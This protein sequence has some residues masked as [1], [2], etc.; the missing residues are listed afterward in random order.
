MA[1]YLLNADHHGNDGIAHLIESKKIVEYV[2]DSFNSYD[3]YTYELMTKVGQDDFVIVDTMSSL[4]ETT[5]GDLKIGSEDDGL[6]WDKREKLQGEAYG[7]SYK[8]AQVLIMR[9]LV[10][11]RKR[12]AHVITTTWETDQR[13]DGTKISQ[14]APDVNPKFFTALLGASSDII[15]LTEVHEDIRDS[16]GNVKVAKG[17]RTLQLRPSDDAVIK[18]QVRRDLVEK[19][20]KFLVNPTWAKLCTTLGKIPSWLTLYGPPGVGKTSLVTDMVNE[21]SK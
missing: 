17:S 11:L 5:R 16:S 19:I 8:T 15:R 2:C 12:R 20:P 9:R 10:N 7:T 6:I 18:V 1:V 13:D 14:R 4:A 3:R 21:G